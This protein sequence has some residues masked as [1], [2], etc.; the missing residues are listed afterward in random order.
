MHIYFDGTEISGDIVTGLSYDSKMLND[1]DMFTLGET[2]C[3]TATIKVIK[4][5]VLQQPSFI[6]FTE[7]GVT[8]TFNVDN[9][10]ENDNEYID[11][12]ADDMV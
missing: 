10:E 12:L 4:S 2:V 6:S 11:S 1:D 3:Y 8:K 5:A 9:I 7:N